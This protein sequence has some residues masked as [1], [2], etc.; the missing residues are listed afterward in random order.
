MEGGIRGSN[1]TEREEGNFGAAIEADGSADAADATIHVELRCPQLKKS[2]NV[3]A[4]AGWKPHG[5]ED[6]QIHLAAMSMPAENQ[7]DCLPRRLRTQLIDIIRR[8]AHQDDR[9]IG[10]VT[11]ARGDGQVGGWLSVARIVKPGEPE[12]ASAA[13][14][15]HVCVA[16]HCDVVEPQGFADMLFTGPDVM[17]AKDGISL[18]ALETAEQLAALP[19]R[20]DG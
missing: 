5:T 9:F 16:K 10:L 12:P 19:G 3:F 6:R 8:M 11:D 4:A 15:R 1:G 7:R 13:F 18:F 2:F 20:V 17:I 14:N